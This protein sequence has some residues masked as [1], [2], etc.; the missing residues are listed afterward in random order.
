MEAAQRV[1]TALRGLRQ[2]YGLQRQRPAVALAVSQP[3]VADGLEA[4]ASCIETL[5]TSSAVTVIRVGY[6]EHPQYPAAEPC[7]RA[8]CLQARHV[9]LPRA[10]EKG[11]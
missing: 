8:S 7:T 9:L 4:A 6:F 3:G 11:S 1:V 2:Q 10:S 5:S